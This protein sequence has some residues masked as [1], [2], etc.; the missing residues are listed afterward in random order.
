MNNTK[1]LATLRAEKNMSQR[2]LAR[3]LNVS[4][5]TI[6]MYEL[7]K[8]TPPLSRAI[9]IA[10]LFNVPVESISFAS[11]NYNNKS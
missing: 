10:Q 6:G 5:G 4:P 11:S 8:R 7:G 2:V 3:E 9:E 1:T